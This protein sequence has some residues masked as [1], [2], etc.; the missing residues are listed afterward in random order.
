MLVWQG[1]EATAET[2]VREGS[3][4]PEWQGWLAQHSTEKVAIP[5]MGAP[6]GKYRAIRD[7]PGLYV[8]ER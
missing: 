7:A 3:W 2:P 8:T 6:G 1:L 4:W 5:S